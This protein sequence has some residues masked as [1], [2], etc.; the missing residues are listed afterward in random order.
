M[1]DYDSVVKFRILYHKNLM[2]ARPAGKQSSAERPLI[3]PTRRVRGG[4]V[5]HFFFTF[6]HRRREIFARI[7]FLTQSN[8]VFTRK[9]E[10]FPNA[11]CVVDR[12]L[13]CL[14]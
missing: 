7:H 13:K 10:N 8:F 5:C 11:H 12:R 14:P 3:V 4:R 2:F 1:T 9:R 6:L